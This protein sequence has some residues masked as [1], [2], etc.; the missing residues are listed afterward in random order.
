MTLIHL[1]M[2]YKQHHGHILFHGASVATRERGSYD[3]SLG[4]PSQ[5]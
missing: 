4:S 3:G 1:I 2:L 5:R